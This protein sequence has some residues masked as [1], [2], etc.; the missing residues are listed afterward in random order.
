MNNINNVH[1]LPCDQ[2]LQTLVLFIDHELP[3][4]KE[5]QI[6]LSHFQECPECYEEMKHESTAIAFLQELLKMHCNEQAPQELHDR[7][8]QQTEALAGQSQVQFF[9]STTV[10][11]FTFDGATSIQV[12]QEFTQEIRHDFN[13]GQ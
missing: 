3:S 6:Y 10:T 13:Q 7:I 4:E 1:Q 12:T 11:N 9:A 5:Y 8:L 2:I